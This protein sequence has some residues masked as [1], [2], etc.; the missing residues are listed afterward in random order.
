MW[1][2]VWKLR[3]NAM[4]YQDDKIRDAL[5]EHFKSLREG[6]TLPELWRLEF[7]FE[8]RALKY[9]R[10]EMLQA[11]FCGFVPAKR[12]GMWWTL[13]YEDNVCLHA[14][15]GEKPVVDSLSELIAWLGSLDLEPEVEPGRISNKNLTLL[16]TPTEPYSY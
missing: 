14:T 11:W 2:L 10:T 3:T 4:K 7:R 13:D 8:I 1:A 12:H 16:T 15:R 9:M 5:R 6:V